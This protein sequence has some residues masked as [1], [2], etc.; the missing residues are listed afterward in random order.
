[1]SEEGA[2]EVPRNAIEQKS[3]KWGFTIEHLPH[4]VAPVFFE[5]VNSDALDRFSTQTQKHFVNQLTKRYSVKSSDFLLDLSGV[6]QFTV[7]GSD[8]PVNLYNL[9]GVNRNLTDEQLFEIVDALGEIH[10]QSGGTIMD[11][12][13]SIM[14]VPENHPSLFVSKDKSGAHGFA[15]AVVPLENRKWLS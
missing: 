15:A 6:Y 7:S 10:A 4:S 2:G 9:G 11:H 3:Q 1:M 13:S 12:L 8:K 5:Q 14:V